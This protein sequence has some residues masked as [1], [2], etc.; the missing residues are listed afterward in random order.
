MR[1]LFYIASISAVAA[2]A[3]LGCAGGQK[4]T[5]QVELPPFYDQQLLEQYGNLSNEG[6]D[7]LQQGNQEAA[8]AA[9]SKQVELIP[10]GRWGHYN[11]ACAS[12]KAGDVEAAFALLDSAVA[13]GWTDAGHF[14]GDPDLKIVREDSRFTALIEKVRALDAQKQQ[15]LAAGLPRYDT[16]PQQFAD[17]LALAA[18]LEEQQGILRA[19]ARAWHPWQAAA[20]SL[21]LEAKRLASMEALKGD[22]F[23]Y[24][25]ER[26]TTMAR[27]K[28]PYEESWGP[29]SATIMKEVEQYLTT[30]PDAESASEALYRGIS[31]AIM[32]D[33]LEKMGTPTGQ[34][35]YAKA[36][37]YFGQMDPSS[38]RYGGAE[39]W[40][41][42]SKLAAAGDHRADLYPEVR[43]FAIK[44]AAD[45]TGMN[46][47]K[48]LMA[49]DI[50]KAS[51]PIPLTA[52]DIDGK[53]VSLDDYK[54]KVVLV[55]F[56]ATW[57]GPCRGELPYL[58]TAYEK[59]KPQGFEILSISLD[60]PDRTDQATY[61]T[62]IGENGM[63][64]RHVYDEKNWVS[65]LT[66]SFA[67]GS[68]P[69]PFMIGKD[70]SLIGMH[71]E[72]RGENLEPLIQKAL[73]MQM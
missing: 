7:A 5:A 51:W 32:Q 15:M 56:W 31:A 29:I 39:A 27:M 61:R 25:L 37:S 2:L 12:C 72:C 30:K 26:I 67:V 33:G 52:T 59:Y 16:P 19:N 64:W 66:T 45:E 24:D 3:G 57:C 41:L 71:D 46:I 58:K 50:V 43:E 47:S 42:A 60:Y 34:T 9:F 10:D 44:Y 18:W 20:A 13:H 21:D 17:T 35:A 62:W 73:A 36:E 8:V 65:P 53:P 70:G 38:K 63:I 68:I 23:D 28:S 6:Y 69:A 54:G 22:Q 14:E 49:G 4:D 11:L 40:L 48:A 1:T 55:D